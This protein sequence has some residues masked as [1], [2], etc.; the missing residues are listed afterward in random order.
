M[1]GN[2]SDIRVGGGGGEIFFGIKQDVLLKV[3]LTWGDNL[4]GMGSFWGDKNV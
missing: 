4:M 3:V 2:W 1:V